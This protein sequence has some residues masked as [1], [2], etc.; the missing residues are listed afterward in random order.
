M[1]MVQYVWVEQPIVLISS[2][3]EIRRMFVVLTLPALCFPFFRDLSLRI[4]VVLFH[5][6][7]RRLLSPTL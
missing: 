6:S 3:S 4:C 2:V 7:D 5:M 1:S